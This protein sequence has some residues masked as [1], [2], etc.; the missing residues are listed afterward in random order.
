MSLVASNDALYGS[1]PKFIA[2]VN[3]VCGIVVEE[4]FSQ[5]RAF[6]NSATHEKQVNLHVMEVLQSYIFT[7]FLG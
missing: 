4:I 3:R 5:L 2:E 7:L 6:D 1:D